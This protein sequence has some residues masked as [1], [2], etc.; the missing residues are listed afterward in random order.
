M[1]GHYE[2]C[3]MPYGLSCAAS[4]FQCLIND[5]LRNMRERFVIAY[6]HDILIYSPDVESHRNHIKVVLSKLLHKPPMVHVKA[7][8]CELHVT[9]VSFLG[10]I[11][12][13]QGITMDQ[14]KVSEVTA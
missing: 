8:K 3:V 4:I 2:F 7:E 6:I 9:H 10:Y 11:I 13:A 14:N 5:M 12:S 1:L